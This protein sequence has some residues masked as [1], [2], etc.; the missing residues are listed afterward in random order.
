MFNSYLSIKIF[1]YPHY[2]IYDKSLCK[3]P[4]IAEGQCNGWNEKKISFAKTIM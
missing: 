1:L 4:L 2:G 3:V